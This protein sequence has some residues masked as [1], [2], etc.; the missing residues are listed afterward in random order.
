MQLKL[1]VVTPLC[2][3][4]REVNKDNSPFFYVGVKL[5]FYI[6]N[7]YLQM[8]KHSLYFLDYKAILPFIREVIVL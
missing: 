8:V 1:P 3:F 2:K 7:K 6:T 4:S 5:I